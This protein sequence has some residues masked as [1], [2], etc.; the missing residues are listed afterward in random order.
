ME[1]VAWGSSKFIVAQ[2]PSLLAATRYYFTQ[3]RYDLRASLLLG[4]PRDCLRGCSLFT[5]ITKWWCVDHVNHVK[6][7]DV[8]HKKNLDTSTRGW[9]RV[10]KLSAQLNEQISAILPNPLSK[11]YFWTDS[12]VT[13]FYICNDEVQPPTVVANW[14]CCIREKTNAHDCRHVPTYANIADIL[15]RGALLRGALPSE[16]I[17]EVRWISANLLGG[18]PW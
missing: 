17:R 16:L 9:S 7:T 18:Q 2:G 3:Q 12:L 14:A 1:P 11:H 4:C 15:S 5:S 13:L 6:R 10:T 8:P